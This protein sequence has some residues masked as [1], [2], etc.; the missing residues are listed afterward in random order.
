MSLLEINNLHVE[1]ETREETVYA[2]NGVNLEVDTNQVL[3]VIGES[4]CGKSVTAMS[5]MRLLESPPGHITEGEIRYDGENLLELSEEEMNEIRGDD[6]SMIYQDPMESLNP[7]LTVGYQV[8]EPLLAH[9]DISKKSA[10]N[11]AIETL[12]K[13]GLADANRIMDEY[14]HSLSGGMQQR[15]MIA[16]AVITDPKLLICDEPTTALDVTI[17]AQILDLL[18]DLRRDFETSM[19]FITHDIPVVSEIADEIAVMYAGNVVEVSPIDRFHDDPLHPYTKLLLESMPRIRQSM[20][21]LPTIDGVVPTFNDPPTG[22]VF[23]SRCP[24]HLGSECD[25]IEPS[26]DLPPETDLN[27]KVACHLYDET[28][29]QESVTASD[30]TGDVQARSGVSEEERS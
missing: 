30:R 11:Q 2:L 15:V 25:E 20:E 3:G 24:D 13:C 29:G 26:L 22:C 14:P 1:F 4:G 19:I 18:S 21:Q 5:I 8:M 16:M 12:K 6:I 10:R 9:R 28:V 27:Q 23:A 17:Q 7:S